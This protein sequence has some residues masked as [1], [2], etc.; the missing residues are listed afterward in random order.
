MSDPYQILRDEDIQ[1]KIDL[2]LEAGMSLADI[3]ASLIRERQELAR[4]KLR[5][6]TQIN[7]IDTQLLNLTEQI[8]YIQRKKPD[9]VQVF[10]EG[11]AQA[12]RKELKHHGG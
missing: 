7:L 4:A 1:E 9:S 8:E 2:N 5:H 11:I 6:Q 3:R 10:A 12:T